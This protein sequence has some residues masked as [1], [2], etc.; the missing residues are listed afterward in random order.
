MGLTGY[1]D[2]IDPDKIIE[3]VPFFPVFRLA[4]FAA[5][6]RIPAEYREKLLEERVKLAIVW[7]NRQL[8]GFR[9][10]KESLGISSLNDVPTD[11][12]FGSDHPSVLLYTRAVSCYAKA[13]LVA[14]YATMM[15]KSDAQSDAN[16]SED[17]ADRWHKFAQD[18]LNDLQ[19][20]PKIHA[21]LL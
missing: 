19:N 12:G 4:D 7:A 17:T 2:Q 5:A 13:L 15:R 14:D 16:E 3:N 8:T 20:K 18:A 9:L 11:D 10:E 1:S 21:E 6:Y